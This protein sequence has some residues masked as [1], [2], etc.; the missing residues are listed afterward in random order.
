M[1]LAVNVSAFACSAVLS[2][3][4]LSRETEFIKRFAAKF[5]NRIKGV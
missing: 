3:R 2:Y 4:Y 5:R 1:R